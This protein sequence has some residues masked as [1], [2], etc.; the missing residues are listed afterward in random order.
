MQRKFEPWKRER[1]FGIK[2]AACGFISAV[3]AAGFALKGFHWPAMGFA[4]LTLVLTKSGVSRLRSAANR[5]FGKR[6]EEVFIERASQE[7]HDYGFTP[8][9][10]VMARGIG[11]IDLVVRKGEVQIPVEIKSF[12]KWNQFFIFKGDREKRALIQADRQRRAIKAGVGIVWVP[13]GRPTFLQRIFGAGSSNVSVVFGGER[14]LVRAV[15]RLM[16]K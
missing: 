1:M 11:D 2:L 7:L 13:Q 4:L 14:V 5:E 15:R 10:N 16:A 8:M 3:V 6:F 9:S 12:R